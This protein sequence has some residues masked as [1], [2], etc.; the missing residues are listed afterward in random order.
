MDSIPQFAEPLAPYVDARDEV[1]KIRRALTL[2]LQSQIAFV[3]DEPPSHLALCSAHNVDGVKDIPPELG[4]GLR[5]QYLRALSANVAARKQYNAALRELA[6]LKEKKRNTERKD[7]S[8]GKEPELLSYLSTLRARREREKVQLFRKYLAKLNDM[9]AAQED[10]LAIGEGDGMIPYSHASGSDTG[11]VTDRV[12]G[13]DVDAILYDLE[14]TT[15]LAQRRLTLERKKFD[16]QRRQKTREVGAG[17]KLKALSRVR[18]ELVQWAEESL[19]SAGT[20]DGNALPGMMVKSEGSSLEPF[21]EKRSRIQGQYR[22][23]LASRQTLLGAIH[24]TTLSLPTADK[25]IPSQKALPQESGDEDLTSLSV[26]LPYASRN[27]L[28][29]SKAQKSTAIQRSYTSTMLEKENWMTCKVLGRLQDESHLLPEY[30]MHEKQSRLRHA[31]NSITNRRSSL[32]RAGAEDK[33]ATEVV[34]HAEAWAFASAAAG[35]TTSDFIEGKLTRGT[36]MSRI[37][38]DALREVYQ[39]MDRDYEEAAMET[40]RHALEDKWTPAAR[41]MNR[42]KSAMIFE[43]QVKS[44]WSALNGKV[45]VLGDR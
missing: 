43:K 10:Y 24:E 11:A 32:A 44:P 16:S 21:E 6:R 34:G 20:D 4:K 41:A 38:E 3:D 27:L 31:L 7:D 14:R 17:V 40:E 29:L 8:T 33:P 18:D 45:G 12:V 15:I 26:F 13:E 36:E 28:P 37:T 35:D 30:P 2:Y 19:A 5:A 1:L 25:T 39:A 23:Y 42:R 22:K 9:E